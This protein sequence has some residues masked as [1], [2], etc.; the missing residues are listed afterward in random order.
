MSLGNFFVSGDFSNSS[1]SESYNYK[2]I[3][4][5]LKVKDESEVYMLL[6]EDER[7][8]KFNATLTFIWPK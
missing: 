6:T 2:R 5:S 7:A 4:N 1:T 3:I 8:L